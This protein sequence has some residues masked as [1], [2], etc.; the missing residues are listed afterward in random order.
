MEMPT[1]TKEIMNLTVNGQET[2]RL[3][4]WLE[5]SHLSLPCSRMLMRYFGTI[6]RITITAMH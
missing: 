3:A 1:D 4:W 6:I 2:L 5:P